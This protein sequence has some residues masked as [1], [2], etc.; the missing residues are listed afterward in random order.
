[1]RC[2]IASVLAAVCMVCCLPQLVATTVACGAIAALAACRASRS[3]VARLVR[4]RRVRQAKRQG[5]G[6]GHRLCAGNVGSRR[7]DQRASCV[8]TPRALSFFCFGGLAWANASGDP[9]GIRVAGRL[10]SGRQRG[11]R[12]SG[13]IVVAS[14]GV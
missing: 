2:A 14:S 4:A 10:G 11:C 12:L 9:P 7:V 3:I 8:P 13:S 6:G 1:V 5:G